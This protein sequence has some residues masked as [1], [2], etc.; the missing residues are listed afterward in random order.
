MNDPIHASFRSYA[1]IIAAIVSSALAYKGYAV[2]D[3]DITELLLAA[4]AFISAFLSFIS[5]VREGKKNG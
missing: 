4:G 3:V 2:A 5:K 1:A